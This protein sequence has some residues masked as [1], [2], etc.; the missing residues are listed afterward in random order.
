MIIMKEIMKIKYLMLGL[1]AL[2]FIGCKK[3]LDADLQNIRSEE[4]MYT[5]PIF[6]QGFVLQSYRL[7]PGYYNNSDLAS[8]DAVANVRTNAF[9][10][11]ATGS[12][13]PTDLTLSVW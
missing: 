4:N 1:I 13:T 11:I 7:I 2:T 6:A 10:Q 8:D 3:L 5:D 9:S 12:W